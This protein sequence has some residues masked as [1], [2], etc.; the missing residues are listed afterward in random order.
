MLEKEEIEEKEALNQEEKESAEPNESSETKEENSESEENSIEALQKQIEELKDKNTRL[1]ADF[2]NFRR[3]SSKE[4]LELIKT[5]SEGVVTAIL[6]IVDDF[7]RAIVAELYGSDKAAQSASMEIDTKDSKNNN[8]EG[9]VLIYNKLQN[10]LKQIGVE[11]IEVKNKAFDDETSEAVAQ[12]PAPEG[13]EKSV[14]IDVVQKGYKLE[15]K[16]IRHAK[17]V[18]GI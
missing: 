15:G 12:V 16:V 1:Y 9:I 13:S 4:K 3:R 17:V 14:V 5:A 2:D 10:I 11:V 6:P 7:E 18:V 8:F